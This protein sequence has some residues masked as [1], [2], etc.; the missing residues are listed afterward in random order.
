LATK[1]ETSLSE[2]SQETARRPTM[3]DVAALA[4]VGLKTV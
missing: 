1:G 4:G 3:L 2:Q